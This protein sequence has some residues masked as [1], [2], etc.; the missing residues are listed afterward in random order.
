VGVGDEAV[1][2]SVSAG[3]FETLRARLLQGR[4]FTEADDGSKPDVAIINRTMARQEFPGEDAIGKR[5]ISQ[6]DPDHPSEIIGVVDDVKDG[7]LDMKPTAAVYSPFNQNPPTIS[8]SRFALL[9]RKRRCFRPWSK[10]IHADRCR[11]DR[12]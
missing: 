11:P 4:Y 2:Q 8:T 3:Y 6:Y 5:I 7:P 10:P 1:D 9:N 12:G